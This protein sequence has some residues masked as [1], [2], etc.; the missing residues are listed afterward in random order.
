M[1]QINIFDQDPLSLVC[2]ELCPRCVQSK[3]LNS[4]KTNLSNVHK[5]GMAFPPQH[6]HKH[7]SGVSVQQCLVNHC[8]TFSTCHFTSP[9]VVTWLQLL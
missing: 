3:T 7:I 1:H 2:K 4:S 6:Y 5:Y 9:P 8:P